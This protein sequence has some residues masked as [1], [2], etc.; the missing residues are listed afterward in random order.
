MIWPEADPF[1]LA[2]S[3]QRVVRDAE[4]RV[5]LRERGRHL[6]QER[7]TGARKLGYNEVAEL[8]QIFTERSY[9]RD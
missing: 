7:F 9:L 2:E 5:A 8:L 1:H 4:V 3:V 6:F